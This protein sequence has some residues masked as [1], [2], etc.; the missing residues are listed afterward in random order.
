MLFSQMTL[1][2]IE[3]MRDTAYGVT[4]PEQREG[5]GSLGLQGPFLKSLI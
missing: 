2:V 4:H 5:A 3:G 1:T